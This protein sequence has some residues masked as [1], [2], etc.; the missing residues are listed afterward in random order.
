[1]EFNSYVKLTEQD[2]QA[3]ELKKS[4]LKKAIKSNLKIAD[5][6]TIDMAGREPRLTVF[7]KGAEK[8]VA[9]SGD[10]LIKNEDGS[11]EVM[12]KKAFKATYKEAGAK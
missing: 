5:N 9:F 6:I 11:F 3:T 4:D 2:I 12:G 1:M 7:G 8:S 10:Y